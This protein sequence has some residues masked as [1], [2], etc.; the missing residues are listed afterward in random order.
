MRGGGAD[1]PVQNVDSQNAP[2]QS[3]GLPLR[4]QAANTDGHWAID[5]LS[6]KKDIIIQLGD[7]EMDP[8]CHSIPTH[9]K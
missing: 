3:S 7:R 1:Q 4:G 6:G 2:T 5:C 8:F 9:K